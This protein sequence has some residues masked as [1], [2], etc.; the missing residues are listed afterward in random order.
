M[1]ATEITSP[2]ERKA[3]RDFVLRNMRLVQERDAAILIIKYAALTREP[4]TW[5]QI[6]LLV[7]VSPAVCKYVHDQ[8]LL[9][10]LRHTEEA[11]LPHALWDWNADLT[12][13][14]ETARRRVASAIARGALVRQPCE[15]CGVGAEFSAAHHRNYYQ[16]LNVTWLCDPCHNEEHAAHPHRAMLIDTEA[17]RRHHAGKG[18][19]VPKEAA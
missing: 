17:V 16:P 13:V 15:S 12:S 6:G 5:Q 8:A 11:A 3:I 19:I 14:K 7:G 1:N 9:F 4:L 10:M 18:T 2:S